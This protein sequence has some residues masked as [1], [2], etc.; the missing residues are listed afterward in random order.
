[1]LLRKASVAWGGI[2]HYT[3]HC[4]VASCEGSWG[5]VYCEIL[6]YHIVGSLGRN[7]RVAE[8]YLQMKP[9]SAF[10]TGSHESD[11]LDITGHFT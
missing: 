1:M 6:V 9:S 11:R 10:Q 7:T 8:V 2:R 3:C 5:V 4:D